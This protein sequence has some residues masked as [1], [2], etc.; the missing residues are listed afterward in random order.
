MR[1]LA[2][3]QILVSGAI[4]SVITLL[5]R[6]IEVFVTMEYYTDP[7]LTGLWS[8]LMMP[9]AGPPPP[10]FFVTS[11]LF[12]FA[13]GTVLAAVFDFMKDLLGKGYWRRVIGFTDIMVGLAIVFAYFPMYLM[14]RVP[15][16]LLVV[17]SVTSF[18]T[19][20]VSAMIYAKR[21]R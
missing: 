10:E 4:A 14:F 20:F 8:T 3:R 5:I 17:W 6:Q 9:A 15:L 18:V 11:V 7:K 13:T 1:K 21:L 16:G 19:I 2:V 12:T